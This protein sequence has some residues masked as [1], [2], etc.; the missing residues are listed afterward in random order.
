MAQFSKYAQ[1]PVGQKTLTQVRILT[2]IMEYAHLVR[3]RSEFLTQVRNFEK[4]VKMLGKKP[5]FLKKLNF[6]KKKTF[7]RCFFQKFC[8]A[9]NFFFG[10]IFSALPSY[11]WIFQGKAAFS[12]CTNRFWRC[13]CW[14]ASYT[15]KAPHTIRH[16]RVNDLYLH[17]LYLYLH[18]FKNVKSGGH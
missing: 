17:F 6:D 7:F 11:S 8:A 3:K 18:F 15:I 13:N 12:P 1:L 9:H 14:T 2:K 4:L 16:N 10:R 5:I